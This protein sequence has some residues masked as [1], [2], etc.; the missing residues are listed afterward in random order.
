ML[1]PSMN[2]VGCSSWHVRKCVR[3]VSAR[4]RCHKAIAGATPGNAGQQAASVSIAC[5]SVHGK[6]SP[7][8]APTSRVTRRNSASC[9][10]GWLLR[11]GR[12]SAEQRAPHGSRAVGAPPLAPSLPRETRVPAETLRQFI[13]SPRGSRWKKLLEQSGIQRQRHGQTLLSRAQCRA[14]LARWYGDLGEFRLK[15]WRVA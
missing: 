3:V 13:G 15:R 4:W 6:R 8:C 14:V 7:S 10:R 5:S 2:R 9:V 11:L 12:R 1:T